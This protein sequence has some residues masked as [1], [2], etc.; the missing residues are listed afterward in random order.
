MAHIGTGGV[1]NH[2]P[3]YDFRYGLSGFRVLLPSEACNAT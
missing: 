3:E 1:M 2:L